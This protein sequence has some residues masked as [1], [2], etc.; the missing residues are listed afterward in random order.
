ME[1][2]AVEP[3]M[4]QTDIRAGARWPREL[5]DNLRETR[6]GI[7]C[8]TKT[9]LNAPW[10]LFE[11]GALAKTIEDTFVCPYLIDFEQ[12]PQGPLSQFQAKHACE[13]ETWELICAINN[14]LKE[15]ALSNER[16][17]EAFDKWWP[18]LKNTLDSLPVEESTDEAPSLKRSAN[19]DTFFDLGMDIVHERL[20]HKELKKHLEASDYI[21]VL[22]TW[23]PE[24][25]VIKKGLRSAI[26]NGATVRLLLCKPKSI[27]LKQR[28]R[29]ANK[30]PRL[31]P[32][33]VYEAVQDVYQW[34][35]EAPPDDD[36]KARNGQSAPA[37]RL[38]EAT[39]GARVQ[40]ACYDS[41]PGCPVIW[42]DEAI[43]MGF[44]FRGKSSTEWPWVSV[45]ATSDL[46]GIL[47]DQFIELWKLRDT[48][49]LNTSKKMASWLKKNKR[50]EYVEVKRRTRKP[51]GKATDRKGVRRMS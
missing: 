46:A 37:G 13:C 39:P 20:T 18:V 45:S 7:I 29:G 50:W 27:L 44:Y 40:I 9:N 15:D 14:A 33:K 42:Y 49:L 5:A 48:E 28:S 3:W 32:S 19:Y 36:V 1:D 24:N 23:F 30:S 22:K 34:I 26:L 31:G 43:L 16:L 12:I 8:I 38:L 17:K 4:S 6:F 25:N 21:I 11:A 35:Q 51:K 41:W 47:E 10:I 2:L